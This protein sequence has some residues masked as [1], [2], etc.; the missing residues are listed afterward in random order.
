MHKNPKK[1]HSVLNI[2]FNVYPN[3]NDFINKTIR[4]II[5]L[6]KSNNEEDKE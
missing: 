2:S 5:E 3:V 4:G 6:N 1:F